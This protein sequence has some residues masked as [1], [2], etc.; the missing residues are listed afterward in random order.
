MLQSVLSWLTGNYPEFYD[1]K[2]AA[3]GKGREVVRT[4]S[5]GVVRVAFNVVTKGLSAHGYTNGAPPDAL[6]LDTEF[7][8]SGATSGLS[9]GG[10]VPLPPLPKRSIS[11]SSASTGVGGR[12]GLLWRRR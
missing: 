11:N 4:T 1:P 7:S 12:G 2:L 8:G 9:S 10:G 3:A 5:T 6:D